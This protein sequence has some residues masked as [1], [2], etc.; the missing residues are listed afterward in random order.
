MK[1]IINPGTRH[2]MLG[3]VPETD[4]EK[5]LLKTFGQALARPHMINCRGFNY[6]EEAVEFYIQSMPLND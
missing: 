4:E 2:F 5:T 6:L 3:L 1:A